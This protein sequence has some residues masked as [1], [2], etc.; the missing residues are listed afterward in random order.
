[1]VKEFLTSEMIEHGKEVIRKLDSAEL[2][3]RSALWLYLEDP[4]K[5]RLILASPIVRI[6][7]P[8]KVYKK[9]K[10]V[11]ASK[12]LDT[13]II[14]LS[15]IS[16]VEDNHSLIKLMSNAI[17]QVPELSEVRFSRNT[18]QGHYIEDALIYRLNYQQKVA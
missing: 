16:V 7:G 18:I 11:L 15:D 5:W 10:Q 12:A 9:V 6:D 14:D 8:K 1:M 17:G 4:E 3:I 2:E 13:N